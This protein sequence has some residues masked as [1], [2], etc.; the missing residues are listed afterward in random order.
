L[1]STLIIN[2]ILKSENVIVAEAS[3]PIEVIISHPVEDIISYNI[4]DIISHTTNA[5]S[6]DLIG[7][8]SPLFKVFDKIKTLNGN[9]FHFGECTMVAHNSEDKVV[10]LL[11]DSTIYV[12]IYLRV[13]LK[14]FLGNRNK[15]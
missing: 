4:E 2:D 3:K 7:M 5:D 13:E 6:K 12:S 8:T 15:M 1:R 14:I 9:L 10:D 11:R